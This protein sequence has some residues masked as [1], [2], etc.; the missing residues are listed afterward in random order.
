[1]DAEDLGCKL[2]PTPFGEPRKT[3]EEQTLGTV[4]ASHKML[5][6]RS[7]SSSLNAGTAR[8]LLGA[9]RQSVPQ[10]GRIRLHITIHFEIITFLI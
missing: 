4:T 7:L 2:L 10:N 8:R 3:P 5:T 9:I 1:M 6:L